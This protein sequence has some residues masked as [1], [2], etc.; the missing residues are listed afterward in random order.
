MFG[1]A[2]EVA[3]NTKDEA[4]RGSLA[5]LLTIQDTGSVAASG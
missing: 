2:N 1:I 3:K 4:L 5:G